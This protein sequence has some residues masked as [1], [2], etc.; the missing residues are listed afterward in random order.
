MQPFQYLKLSCL[1]VFV[2]MGCA[3]DAGDGGASGGALATGGVSN[4]TGGSSISGGSGGTV[5]TPMTGGTAPVAGTT[6]TGGAS[7]AGASNSGGAPSNG[8]SATTGRTPSTGGTQATGGSP[9]TGGAPGTGGSATTGGAQSQGGTNATGGGGA[10]GKSTNG[11]TGSGGTGTGGASTGGTATGGASTGGTGTAGTTSGSTPDCNS[12]TGQPIVT[13]AK[14]GTGQ[15]S[16]VQAAVNS[17]AT[18]NTTPTQ[19]RIKPG[20][21]KEKLTINRPF[22]TLCGE[23]GKAAST[24]LTYSDNA[25]T[26]NGNGGTLGT[27]GGTSVNLSSSDVSVENITFENSTPLGGSQAVALLVSGSRVQFRNCRFMSYQDTLYV[28]SGSQ[29]FKNSYIQGSVDFIF[30]GAT[31]VFDACT[32]H[33][34]SGGVSVTAPSTE[35]TTTYGLVFLGGSLTAASGVSKG[36][37]ALG[38]NWRP[39]GAAAYIKTALGAHILPAGWVPMGENTLD[40]ARFSEYQNTGDGSSTAKRVAQSTQLS[41]TAVANYTIPKIFGSW[42][43]SFSR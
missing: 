4:G 41:A 32:V 34:A 12:V 13:V 29:Y 24:I 25:N 6:S 28:K 37:V 23:A 19:I 10:G 9:S 7:G 22:I 38:R 33:S 27:T 30:G 36:S 11:G 18:S 1:G 35:Q 17:I 15:F 14:D 42:T 8:G 2:A 20:S 3:S 31:A 26:S 39:Y 43:P 5:S 21:Y 40:T 16:T